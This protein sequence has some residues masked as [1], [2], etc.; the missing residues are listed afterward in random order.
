MIDVRKVL[1]SASLALTIVLGWAGAAGAHV[2]VDP[3]SAPQGGTVKLS[4]LAPNEE[5]P[6]TVTELQIFF[7]VPPQTPIPTVTVEPKPGWTFHLTNL[8]LAKPIVTDD[9][10][11][12]QIV[13]EIDWKADNAA[14]A[15][16]A[17]QF[18]EFIIDADGLPDHGT[19]V[20]FKA[21][22]TYSNGQVVRWI[23][24][25]TPG[26]PDPAHPTP[27]LQLTSPGGSPAT[28]ATSTT[29]TAASSAK[30]NTAR[31]IAIAA[32]IVGVLAIAGTAILGTRRRRAA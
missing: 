26:Q 9:G 32:L 8:H 24:P 16:G 2:T 17:N 27:I 15:I 7:P 6:A 1:V 19:Q 22:Q 18:G 30:D 28:P 29:A 23:D 25:V 4:F 3:P 11:I 13:S 31:T 21:L 14:A 20:V 5:P 10:S 12:A